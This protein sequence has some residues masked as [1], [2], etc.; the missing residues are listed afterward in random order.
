[1]KY[2]RIKQIIGR[3]FAVTIDKKLIN[4]YCVIFR[5]LKSKYL[6]FRLH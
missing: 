4:A 2:V 1:M 5:P 3:K 6:S